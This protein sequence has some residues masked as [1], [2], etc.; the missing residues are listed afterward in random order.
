MQVEE[1]GKG[2]EGKLAL[3]ESEDETEASMWKAYRATTTDTEESISSG[4]GAGGSTEAHRG[5]KPSPAEVMS[6]SQC[7]VVSLAAICWG[8][9]HCKSLL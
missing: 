7:R 3:A 6:T 4:T 1:G 8:K 2:R 9:C 5:A